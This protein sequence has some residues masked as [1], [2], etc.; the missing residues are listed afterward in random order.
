MLNTLYH[1]KLKT[2]RTEECEKGSRYIYAIY[3]IIFK[4]LNNKFPKSRKVEA[5]HV[6]A[7][8][9]QSQTVFTT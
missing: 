2:L 1:K 9:I 6:N 5:M 3:V 8:K 4:K 7:L